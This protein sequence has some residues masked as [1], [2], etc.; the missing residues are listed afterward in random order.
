[1]GIRDFRFILGSPFKDDISIGFKLY[2][3]SGYNLNSTS[4][5]TGAEEVYARISSNLGGF[6]KKDEKAEKG[7]TVQQDIINDLVYHLIHER[8]NID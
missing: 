3:N 8:L 5:T 4:A 6:G 1:V 2:K 7:H